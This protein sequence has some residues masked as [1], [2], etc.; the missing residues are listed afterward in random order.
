MWDSDEDIEKEPVPV[1]QLEWYET[2]RHILEPYEPA[3]NETQADK[4]FTSAEIISSIEQHHGVPQGVIGKEIHQL[5]LPGDFVR[6]MRYLGY[7]EANA[8][9]ISLLWILKKKKK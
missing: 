9:G 4:H 7:Q 5:V 1:P 6:A 2:L 3:K 8:G